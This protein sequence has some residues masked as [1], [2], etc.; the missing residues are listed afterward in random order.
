MDRNYNKK[1]GQQT[2]P[3]YGPPA[4]P[5]TLS[6]GA[7]GAYKQPPTLQEILGQQDQSP[8]D[9]LKKLAS[10]PRP[11]AQPINQLER[12][13]V[14]WPAAGRRSEQKPRVKVPVKLQLELDKKIENA[15]YFAR[16]MKGSSAEASFRKQLAGLYQ[17]RDARTRAAQAEQDH[18]YDSPQAQKT[19][20]DFTNR[21]TR[22]R[23]PHGQQTAA[24]E[25]KAGQGAP[26]RSG[27]QAPW[28]PS[29]NP[30]E[31]FVNEQTK[32]EKQL[33]LQP[34]MLPV[35]KIRQLSP[36]EIAK[37]KAEEAA[38]HKAQ[39]LLDTGVDLRDA[40][41]A[42]ARG[43]KDDE[44]VKMTAPYDESEEAGSR[45]LTGTPDNRSFS[46]RKGAAMA[47]AK[48]I[49][50]KDYKQLLKPGSR[51]L[52]YFDQYVK[53]VTTGDPT[54]DDIL[55]QLIEHQR[56]SG[57]SVLSS[58]NQIAQFRNYPD[59]YK[60]GSLEHFGRNLAQGVLHPTQTIRNSMG[61]VRT[62]DELSQLEKPTYAVLDAAITPGAGTAAKGGVTLAGK[63]GA[64]LLPRL[65]AGS[66][67]KA[68]IK[69]EAGKLVAES[70]LKANVRNALKGAV[71]QTAGMAPETL[72]EARKM[73]NTQGIPFMEALGT[74]AKGAVASIATTKYYDP[75]EKMGLGDR[76]V[77]FLGQAGALLGA[78]HIAHELPGAR[79]TRT[80]K[81]FPELE[82]VQDIPT[83]ITRL[84]ENALDGARRYKSPVDQKLY[85][86]NVWAEARP[87]AEKL[88]LLQ[89]KQAPVTQ[90]ASAAHLVRFA[91]QYINPSARKDE[92]DVAIGLHP[93]VKEVAA[94]R[95]ID[96]SGYKWHKVT[97][98]RVRHVENRHGPAGIGNAAFGQVP[99][100]PEDYAWLP[101]VI[102]NPD[103]V[104]YA[105]M[106]K[107]G[108]PVFGYQK[109]INGTL[110][111]L[112]EVMSPRSKNLT[113]HSMWKHPS[114]TAKPPAKWRSGPAGGSEPPVMENRVLP[115]PKRSPFG[116]KLNRP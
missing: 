108:M 27:Q 114:S 56:G 77:G 102:S 31:K 101:K 106:S 104:H 88:G 30:L 4:P 39:R 3:S 40:F 98:D 48:A 44:P 93:M 11:T 87:Y 38:T 6:F 35:Q 50:L 89:P 65:F 111:Y 73:Q 112:E 66:A 84:A 69:N 79:R 71:A 63:A 2:G 59:L 82:N 23:Q 72:I 41:R 8:R 62:D 75:R 33:G 13:R 17:L 116:R 7:N 32:L 1:K 92:I 68:A 43:K 29:P 47:V 53:A 86:D 94:R 91:R 28:D 113:L 97:S 51:E 85:L 5:P 95:G 103:S 107:S 42:F 100:T 80:I 60:I 45:W 81:V 22:Q 70:V 37:R 34:S 16:T 110:F 109:K 76:A 24:S 26:S 52:K 20:T 15:E 115:R 58:R 9:F 78:K 21:N 18:G 55:N 74:T 36:A 49:G 90:V 57:V 83:E 67:A 14:D 54:A 96:L 12:A 64:K 19:R 61:D 105:G 25:N 99:L 10:Q 46:T